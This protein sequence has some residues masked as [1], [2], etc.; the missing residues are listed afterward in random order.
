MIKN[1][2]SEASVVEAKPWPYKFPIPITSVPQVEFQCDPTL[3]A[4][5]SSS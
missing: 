3:L 1:L 5:S 4:S 2:A